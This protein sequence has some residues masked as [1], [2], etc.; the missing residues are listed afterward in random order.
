MVF[1]DSDGWPVEYVRGKWFSKW[2]RR[3]IHTRS[4]RRG[5]WDGYRVVPPGG[6]SFGPPVR[7]KRRTLR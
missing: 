6:R 7:L 5:W 1:L 4:I 3:L 2:I